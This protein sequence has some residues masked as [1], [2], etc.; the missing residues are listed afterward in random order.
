VITP[1]QEGD[2]STTAIITSGENQITITA[3]APNGEE[4][5]KTVT[6]TY[7]TEEF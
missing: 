6:V 3:I 2:F 1:S 7:S 4:V 5:K